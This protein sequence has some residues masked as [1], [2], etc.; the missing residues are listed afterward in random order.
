[1]ANIANTSIH[2]YG[3]KSNLDALYAYIKERLAT[4]SSK[5]YSEIMGIPDEADKLNE[6]DRTVDVYC[7]H[8][9]DYVFLGITDKWQ[10]HLWMWYALAYEFGCQ[11]YFYCT[12]L[13]SEYAATDD[14][15][16]VVSTATHV[17][18]CY[19]DEDANAI[20]KDSDNI[21]DGEEE[22]TLPSDEDVNK[23]IQEIFTLNTLDEVQKW[24]NENA[25]GSYFNLCKYAT[26]DET[27]IFRKYGLCVH[28]YKEAMKRVGT[29][30][31]V[32]KV[33]KYIWGL[34]KAQLDAI[35]TL[36]DLTKSDHDLKTAL[37]LINC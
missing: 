28:R 35:Y 15:N 30:Y 2:I 27:E 20:L 37:L 14:V 17:V 5:P 8:C 36:L 3:E 32:Y 22:L 33:R 11:P 13:A 1:M 9:T 16:T 23:Y 19:L 29:Q 31:D 26:T 12:E 24:L 18:D 25:E 34:E 7:E 21:P 10:Q 4:A 6:G